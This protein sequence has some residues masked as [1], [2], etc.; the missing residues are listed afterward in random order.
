MNRINLRTAGTVTVVCLFAASIWVFPGCGK[1]GC[2]KKEATM[3]AQQTV[4]ED[5][6]YAESPMTEPSDLSS[7]AP[8]SRQN[9]SVPQVIAE[10]DGKFTVQVAS[11]RTR[12]MAEKD[13]E[14]YVEQGF[15]AYI[16]PADIPEKGGTWYR[17]RVGSFATLGEA[18]RFSA[19][20]A[21]LLESGYW[22]DRKRE[23]MAER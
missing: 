16:Q 11:W 21:G 14:R 2:G 12:R 7:Q 5:T 17:V 19:Q 13:A 6:T 22:V 18:N 1:L 15:E 4:Q 3:P 20:L 10:A 8:P 23:T 9:Q